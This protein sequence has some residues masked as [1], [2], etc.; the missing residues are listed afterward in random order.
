MGWR[1]ITV[2]LVG[3]DLQKYHVRTRAGYR[4]QQAHAA[5]TNSAELDTVPVKR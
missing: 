4:V 5:A 3:K 2:K 1:N